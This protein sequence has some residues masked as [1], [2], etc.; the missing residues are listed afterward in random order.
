MIR[1][2]ED[3]AKNG[4]VGRYYISS[5]ADIIGAK[6]SEGLIVKVNSL[7]VPVSEI[8]YT[9]FSKEGDAIGNFGC[10]IEQ[11]TIFYRASKKEVAEIKRRQ[12]ETVSSE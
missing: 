11:F 9:L 6:D 3:L 10:S 8:H 2:C 4:V 5:G 1:F 7:D 12:R